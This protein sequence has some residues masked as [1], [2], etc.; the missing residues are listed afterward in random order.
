M[1]SEVNERRASSVLTGQSIEQVSVCH[2]FFMLLGNELR[3][4]S[5][6]PLSRHVK[7]MPSSAARILLF[8]LY[9]V[10]VGVEARDDLSFAIELPLSRL[11][12]V[13]SH[14]EIYV[15]TV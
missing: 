6:K 9:S 7:R 2:T 12:F 13:R 10:V 4:L 5:R 3:R 15:V 11:P 1:R 8:L 14:G